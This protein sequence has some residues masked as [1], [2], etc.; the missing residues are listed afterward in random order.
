MRVLEAKLE[1]RRRR[2]LRI[3]KSVFGTTGRPRM[4]VF[5]SLNQIYAQIIDDERG[6]TLCSASSRDKGRDAAPR[7]GGNIAAA[8]L[9]GAALAERAKGA[10]VGQV[11]FDRNGYKYHGRIKAL[12]D[13][14]RQG[15]LQF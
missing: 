15:G 5:R 8:K 12:A 4:T 2:K 13:A 10:G 6:T 9:V 3:R 7:S 1:R 11:C 14:A